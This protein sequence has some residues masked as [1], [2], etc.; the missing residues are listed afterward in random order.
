MKTFCFT[1]DDNI[2]FLRELC[3]G[4]MPSLFSHPY[5]AMLKRLHDLYGVKIQL[6]LFYTD[7]CFTLS[8][9]TDRYR[10]EWAAVSGWLRLSFHSKLENVK[11]YLHSSYD[12]VHRDCTAVHCE[13]LRFAGEASLAKTTT[14]HYCVSTRDGATA[15]YNCG[16]RGLLALSGTSEKPYVCYGLPIGVTSELQAGKVVTLDGISYADIDAVLNKLALSEIEP[17]IR[18]LS[19]RESLRLMIHEQYFYPNY[20]AYQPDFEEKLETAFTTLA[21]LG[22]ESRFFEQIIPTVV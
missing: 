20:K 5:A 6:N 1:I 16:V 9:M 10:D 19:G 22:F 18:K 7:G 3:E 11:P 12:D 13:I 4:E 14:L 17:L 15:L 8:D 21:E 2:R